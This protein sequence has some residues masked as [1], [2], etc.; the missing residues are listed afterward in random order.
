MSKLCCVPQEWLGQWLPRSA[1]PRP[2][3]PADIESAL[4]LAYQVLHWE[5]GKGIPVT[6]AEVAFAH[7]LLKCN[8]R[9]P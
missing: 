4:A 3:L 9:E 5:S 2:P 6:K 8:G 1:F 7:A